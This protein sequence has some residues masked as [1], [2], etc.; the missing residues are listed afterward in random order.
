M[1]LTEP[2]GRLLLVLALALLSACSQNDAAAPQPTSTT[3]AA[4]ATRPTALPCGREAETG[5]AGPDG[6]VPLGA[7]ASPSNDFRDLWLWGSRVAYV[8]EERA[9]VVC[10]LGTGDARVVGTVDRA[11][12]YVHT[13]RGSGDTV[14]WAEFEATADPAGLSPWEIRA[15]DL[16][17]GRTWLVASGRPRDDH[18]AFPAPVI[19]G[20][21]ITW[22]EV[23]PDRSRRENPDI[24]AY[25]VHARTRRV[26][27]AG[28]YPLIS[29][30]QAYFTASTEKGADLYV[31]PVD[32]SSPARRLTHEGT[33]RG[34]DAR[35][36]WVVW[37]RSEDRDPR[38]TAEDR[39]P[40]VALQAGSTAPRVVAEGT[41]SPRAGNGFVV[42]DSSDVDGYFLVKI[43]GT[44]LRPFTASGNLGMANVSVDGDRIAWA[45]VDDP[46][47]KRK[48][49]YLR[50]GRVER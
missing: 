11:E 32:G 43:D 27:A 42:A 33:V 22:V 8:S 30:G 3:T 31:V 21:T 39:Q 28:Y 36:G 23:P 37:T 50:I 25:D 4:A 24:V 12:K 10:D 15:H 16:H 34:M 47:G 7:F 6:I 44:D 45:T 5:P 18:P 17:N 49:A 2:G 9:V 20:S 26:L 38:V 40:I 13:A 41:Y 1:T 48:P 46:L 29:D 35:N 14:V 19:E